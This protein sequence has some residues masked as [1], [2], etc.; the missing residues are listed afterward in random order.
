MPCLFIPNFDFEAHLGRLGRSIPDRIWFL[1]PLTAFLPGH[2]AV[3]VPEA[4]SPEIIAHHRDCG[5]TP[6]RFFARPELF[7]ADQPSTLAKRVLNGRLIFPEF[8]ELRFWGCPNIE[9][10]GNI[11]I[12]DKSFLVPY[13]QK[14]VP[15]L[16]STVITDPEKLRPRLSSAAPK[17]IVIKSCF[18]A[19]AQ[20]Q[21]IF[22]PPFDNSI[23]NKILR[24]LTREKKIIVEQWMKRVEDFSLL[25]FR[26]NGHIKFLGMTQQ[27]IGPKG[28]YTGAVIQFST[29]ENEPLIAHCQP[30]LELI[31][32]TN[33]TGP[34][35]L[36]IFSFKTKNRKLWTVS[37]I[38][39]RHS[40]GEIAL[41]FKTFLPIEG[42][43]RFCI[44]RIKNAVSAN[45]L[46]TRLKKAGLL[47]KNKPRTGVML[48]LLNAQKEHISFFISAK[49]HQELRQITLH[50]FMTIGIKTLKT[51]DY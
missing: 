2:D 50:T 21:W 6:P 43:G 26:E 28:G 51:G 46:L 4:P 23:Q 34:F 14:Y 11:Q 16:N 9:S 20:G 27:N 35:G 8:N 18:G 40:F 3:L 17:N 32:A 39:G 25:F 5:L 48:L 1:A 36:D 7:Q 33:Y 30:V 47:Y 13:K 10:P 22:Q 15:N 42:I 24:L 45:E 31:N 19:S 44:Q 37:E 12:N 29:P 41:R 49:S 38:N